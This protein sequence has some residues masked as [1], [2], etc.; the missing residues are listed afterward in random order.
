PLVVLT[1]LQEANHLHLS[2][3]V[4]TIH[5]NFGLLTMWTSL[6]SL[7]VLWIVSQRNPK[8]FRAVFL[9]FVLAIAILVTVTGHQ[10]GR[11]VY[12]Y[13]VGISQ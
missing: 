2:H 4:L 5:K 7:P 8:L 9:I 12:E 1:G 11:M 13:G 10:G 6:I 3:P